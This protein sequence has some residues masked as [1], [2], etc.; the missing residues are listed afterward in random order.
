VF[1][2]TELDRFETRIMMLLGI[3]ID[4]FVVFFAIIY[5]NHWLWVMLCLIFFQ[6]FYSFVYSKIFSNIVA[7]KIN[8]R[9][10]FYLSVIGLQIVFGSILFWFYR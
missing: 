6:I 1:S 3:P 2:Y 5:F 9:Y 10:I 8:L 4:I 7:N